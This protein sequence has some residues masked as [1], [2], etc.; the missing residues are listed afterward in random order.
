MR[1]KNIVEIEQA[2]PAMQGS[3][4]PPDP[5]YQHEPRPLKV[6]RVPMQHGWY[7]LIE[8]FMLWVRSPAF[9]SFL[10]FS[11]ILGILV[12][13]VTPYVGELLGP[14]L[15]PG[16]M[17]GVFNGCRA[18]DRK[19]KL[20]PGL[21]FTGF[22]RHAYD[23]LLAGFCNYIVITMVLW[24]TKLIDGGIMW[25]AFMHAEIP[26]TAVFASPWFRYSFIT[27]TVLLTL[28]GVVYLFVPQ[29]IG[30]WRLS[31]PMA[32]I[33]SLKGCLLNWLPFLAYSFCFGFFVCMLAAL[34][35]NFLQLTVEGLGVLVCTVF[36]LIIIPTL[37]ASFYVAARDIFG[38]PRRRK[39]KRRPSDPALAEH[40]K[41]R[42]DEE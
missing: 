33:F 4:L 22:R 18:I 8:G 26:D 40:R 2:P 29:L 24:G 12:A 9:L 36:L 41:Q 19:R 38:L 15:Y 21:L 31:V 3:A 6:R 34:V 30:W 14:V 39:H 10:A 11:C 23:L 25:Q 20:S 7:W 32:L 35:I 28:W 27:T 42:Q 17:L 1:N 13:L 5:R 37:F 16:L